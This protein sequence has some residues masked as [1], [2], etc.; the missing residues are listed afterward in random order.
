[1]PTVY[2]RVITSVSGSKAFGQ[3]PDP[4]RQFIGAQVMVTNRGHKHYRGIIKD[5]L[6]DNFALVELEATLHRTRIKLSDLALK[7]VCF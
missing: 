7:Y 2:L 6:S 5:V 3:K 1:V 4:N